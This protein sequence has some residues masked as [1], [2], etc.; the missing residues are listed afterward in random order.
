MLHPVN[1]ERFCRLI[2]ASQQ[3]GN[4]GIFRAPN[5]GQLSA[6]RGSEYSNQ[7]TAHATGV[8][9]LDPCTGFGAR[10]RRKLSF[11]RLPEYFED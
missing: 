6:F 11:L 5:S 7:R 3:S 1:Q 8:V 10:A 4:D 2:P 9:D